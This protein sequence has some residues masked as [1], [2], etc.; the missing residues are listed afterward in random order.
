[1]SRTESILIRVAVYLRVSTARQL[2]GYGLDVQL[3]ECLAWLDFAVGKGRYAY[4]VYT[5]GAV[6]GTLAHRPDLT[7]LDADLAR[8]L[9]DVV[10]FGK[11]DRIGRTMRGIHRWVYDT[12]DIETGRGRQV[13]VATADG[14]IDSEHPMFG[15]QLSLLAY[16]AELEHTLILERTLSGREM[17]LAAGG[18]PGGVAPF[19]LMLPARG[20]GGALTLRAQGVELLEVGAWLI[21]DEQLSA[22]ESA[23]NLNALGYVTARGL[24]WTGDNLARVFRETALD[25]YVAFRFSRHRRAGQE[26]EA[27]DVA[28]VQGGAVRI[29]V[30]MPL[31]ADRVRQVRDVL[32]RRSHPRAEEKTYLLSGRVV[33]LCG[34]HYVGAHREGRGRTAYRCTGRRS[35]PPCSCGE[36]VAGPLED[37]VWRELTKVLV[38]RIQLRVVAGDWLGVVPGQTRSLAGRLADLDAR[39]E[40]CRQVRKKKLIAIAG[41]VT[42]G[43]GGHTDFAEELLAAFA[44][45]EDNFVDRDRRLRVLRDSVADRL[46]AA[47]QQEVQARRVLEI[48]VDLQGRLELLNVDQRREL[49]N[50]LDVQVRTVT[51]VPGAVRASGC[52]FEA[53]FNEHQRAVPPPLTDDQWGRVAPCFPAPLKKS[54]VVPP[55]VAFEASLYKARHGLKWDALPEQVLQGQRA[56]SLYQRALGYLHGGQWQRAVC[57]LGDYQG[58]LVPPL[59]VLPDID[60]TCTFDATLMV[61]REHSG[62]S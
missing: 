41:A 7:D 49:L 13:R 39:I 37:A 12:T 29:P 2:C 32:A 21:A 42:A 20:A 15:I 56:R 45:I 58:T 46:A 14:R 10:V 38:D 24:P 23:E 54:R 19:W 8:C 1:M 4:A 17:K 3:S 60:I 47:Q 9:Y 30:P 43:G 48:G 52:P 6:S 61:D 55:R 36:I 31:P 26:F 18:W 51:K 44:E 34:Q 59:Y 53:W 40:S 16:M 50:L 27:A 11:L 35:D 28:S 62:S 57:A 25:G 33:A 22:R 5:D